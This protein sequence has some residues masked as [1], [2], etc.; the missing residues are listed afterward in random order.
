MP[1][2]GGNCPTRTGRSRARRHALFLRAA[3][4]QEK[5][6]SRVPGGLS[7]P[8]PSLAQSCRAAPSLGL[9]CEA[10]EKV[11]RPPVGWGC[12]VGNPH[13]A[14]ASPCL[15]SPR[16][17]LPRLALP[18]PATGKSFGFNRAS[19]RPKGG[20]KRP[21]P[22]GDGSKPCLARPSPTLPRLA[23]PYPALPRKCKQV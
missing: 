10:A 15:A 13:Q 5:S 6:C 3:T 21:P 20:K 19:S 17:A 2:E 22:E 1:G 11:V 9:P 16:H 12:L 4:R 8:G 7:P 23:R 18:C 14:L